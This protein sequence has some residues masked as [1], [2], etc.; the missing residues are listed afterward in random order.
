MKDKK[1]I[2]ID[3]IGKVNEK[4]IENS[5]SSDK[6]PSLLID[7]LITAQSGN[8]YEVKPVPQPEK[9]KFPVRMA[10]LSGLAAALMISAAALVINK[11][12][13]G[14]IE[15][16]G[17]ATGTD[18]TGT[19]AVIST[20]A[21]VT[22]VSMVPVDEDDV[23]ERIQLDYLKSKYPE[24]FECSTFKGLEIYPTKDD[25]GYLMFRL[26]SGTDMIKTEEQINALPAISGEDLRL[27]LDWYREKDPDVVIFVLDPDNYGQ[28]LHDSE[29]ND[30]LGLDSVNDDA[31]P[32]ESADE[33]DGWDG[34]A[35][36]RKYEEDDNG[37]SV[38]WFDPYSSDNPGE[39]WL[40]FKKM[41]VTDGKLYTDVYLCG[42]S[43]FA[44]RDDP[45][46]MYGRLHV[47]IYEPGTGNLVTWIDVNDFPDIYLQGQD[48]HLYSFRSDR[49]SDYFDIFTFRDPDGNK[50]YNVIKTAY[51][52]YGEGFDTRF[53]L[54]NEDG[55][56]GKFNYNFEKLA[57]GFKTDGGVMLSH[58]LAYLENQLFDLTDTINGTMVRF[59]FENHE[60]WIAEPGDPG[61]PDTN[62]VMAVTD[63]I[64][65]P[66]DDGTSEDVITVDDKTVV[67]NYYELVKATFEV[68][69]QSIYKHEPNPGE[70]A[71]WYR[72]V[73][74]NGNVYSQETVG[75][76][77]E[78]F[79]KEIEGLSVDTETFR[80]LIKPYCDGDTLIPEKMTTGAAGSSTA[81]S[82]LDNKPLNG[83]YYYLNES[84]V[85][86]TVDDGK[87][88]LVFKIDTK[89]TTYR[90]I[91]E[92]LWRNYNIRNSM[93][94]V[95]VKD[96]DTYEEY[97]KIIDT[98]D[99][100]KQISALIKKEVPGSDGLY[101]TVTRQ[102]EEASWLPIT[103]VTHNKDNTQMYYER[104]EQIDAYNKAFDDGIYSG[105]L[106]YAEGD[107]DAIADEIAELGAKEE[108]ERLR[109]EFAQ[110]HSNGLSFDMITPYDSI[111]DLV[112]LHKYDDYAS[113]FRITDSIILERYKYSDIGGDSFEYRILTK[114]PQLT[115]V[116]R[117]VIYL[118]N[119][120]YLNLNGMHFEGSDFPVL[121]IDTGFG[122]YDGEKL[123]IDW[124]YIK[125]PGSTEP[126]ASFIFIAD[127]PIP[128]WQ[129]N[130]SEWAALVTEYLCRETGIPEDRLT[131]T[132]NPIDFGDIPTYDPF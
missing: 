87:N 82:F 18:N 64:V 132:S 23:K 115:A 19:N 75:L 52:T 88:F 95:I 125:T 86:G 83:K 78:N 49:L 40:Y 117:V 21:P 84:Y 103:S 10:V 109:K 4:Y 65:L 22:T 16:G 7:D 43:V 130:Y 112:K 107:Y 9:K 42:M 110:I 37:V 118:R 38:P 101:R 129:N 24:Y 131:V 2:L 128:G 70:N 127:T 56:L 66:T 76:S 99:H 74:V 30:M 13:A 124:D 51:G 126:N 81:V 36:F 15:A 106:A 105:V 102:Q 116:R 61:T 58:S 72:M 97:I 28:E 71:P 89:H 100:L 55:T 63:D 59:D 48:E 91:I 47:V 73:C 80:Q 123:I 96:F 1:D 25:T 34:T 35:M 119:F 114:E 90:K 27:I 94:V 104:I 6:E 17:N 120:P 11:L 46:I 33:A 12:G 111:F 31:V 121:D 68:Q 77:A 39:D 57:E 32:S 98:E 26:A 8:V 45:N 85:L 5:M 67:T 41:T 50:E 93:A 62:P 122:V 20:D 92:L 14:K 108:A 54:L 53:W 44:D 79:L 29:I 60:L 113:Y 3:A 69:T